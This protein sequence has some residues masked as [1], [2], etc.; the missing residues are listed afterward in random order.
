[1]VSDEFQAIALKGKDS[2]MATIGR[3]LGVGMVFATQTVEHLI[4]ALGEAEAA[5]LLQVI[6]SQ[7]ALAGRSAK[8]DEMIARR[9]GST[10]RATIQSMP[11]IPTTRAAMMVQAAAGSRAAAHHHTDIGDAISWDARG[12]E[13]DLDRR[14][15]FGALQFARE[16]L[17]RSAGNE[18]HRAN[19]FMMVQP[20]CSIGV[21][22]LVEAAEVQELVAVPS[23]ALVCINRGRVSRRDVVNLHVAY[24]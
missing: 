15:G 10:F 6:G 12:A 20:M 19:D 22:P 3:S 9:I 13:A 2:D 17:E 16:E 21:T 11:G 7:I 4:A 1:M 5:A 14:R 24:A 23:S 8:T 18:E